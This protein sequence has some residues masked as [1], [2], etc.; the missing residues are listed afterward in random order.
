LKN[1]KIAQGDGEE[2]GN[3]EE[4]DKDRG[5]RAAAGEQ[6]VVELDEGD[7]FGVEPAL[8]VAVDG[9]GEEERVV[10]ADR[11]TGGEV[12]HEEE[13]EGLI[14][15]PDAHAQDEAVVVTSEDAPLAHL[16]RKNDKRL[17]CWN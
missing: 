17:N 3:V 11:A 4:E 10:G 8:P 12:E 13:E 14:V 16:E 2:E 6:D 7:V 1:G 5:P 15:G 9:L